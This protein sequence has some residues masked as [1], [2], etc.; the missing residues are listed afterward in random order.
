MS[1]SHPTK[2]VTAYNKSALQKLAWAIEASQGQFSLIF[3]H[4]NYTYI[5]QQMTQRLAEIS[6]VQIREIVLKKSEVRL[7]TKI[8]Y[9]LEDEQPGTVIVFGLESVDDLDKLLAATNQVREE[10][11]KSFHCPVVLWIND[12]V[13]TKLVRVAPDFESWGT[14]KKFQAPPDCLSYE[15]IYTLSQKAK[16]IL[17]YFPNSN[18]QNFLYRLKLGLD[19]LSEFESA[20]QDLQDHDQ[21]I[22][23]ELEAS[24]YFM[25]GRN[26][27][28]TKQYEQSFTYYQQSLI[29]WKKIHRI[30]WQAMVL[31][32]IGLCS[33][34]K[35][36]EYNSFEQCVD[37]LCH[38]LSLDLVNKFITQFCII[39]QRSHRWQDLETIAQKALNLHQKN[40]LS[41]ELAQDYS[42]LAEVALAQ[43]AW[44]KAKQLAEAGLSILTKIPSAQSTVTSSRQELKLDWVQSLHRGWDLLLLAIAENGLGQYQASINYLERAK[45]KTKPH[46]DPELYIRIL[47]NLREVY[48]K[49]GNY[50]AA[51]KV[52]QEKICIEQ[53][54]G[55]RVF[56]GAGK[57]QPKPKRAK[58]LRLTVDQSEMVA[59]EIIASGRQKD[60]NNLLARIGNTKCKL[61]VIHGQSGVGKSS[62][63]DAGLVPILKQQAI[64]QRDVK[65]IVIRVYTDWVRELVRLLFNGQE[66]RE[67]SLSAEPK[68]LVNS[69]QTKLQDNA[70]RNLL[71]ILIFDQFEESFF[72]VKSL[73]EQNILFDFL[74]ICI[75]ELPHTKVILS[76]KEDY[77]HYLLKIERSINLQTTKDILNK[78]V[79]YNL[80]N[81][82]LKDINIDKFI[83]N[84]TNKTRF[85]L[86]PALIDQLV[87][88]LAG[89]CGEIRP[90]E[91]QILGYQLQTEKIT[92]LAAYHKS[93]SHQELLTRFLKGVISDCGPE[94]ES[95][96]QHILFLL[97]DENNTRPFK[98]RT[99]LVSELL[100]SDLRLKTETLN[101][102]LNILVNSGLVLFVPEHPAGRYQ[103]VHDYLVTFIRRQQDVI[104]REQGTKLVAELE[105]EKGER[106]LI[107]VKRNQ[108]KQRSL[109]SLVTVS[110]VTAF[111]SLFTVL[112]SQ[113]AKNSEILA[114]NSE[115][116][117]H[118]ESSEALYNRNRESLDPLVE[119]LKAG[120]QVK[121]AIRV[122]TDNRTQTLAALQQAVYGVREHNRLEEKHS[123][124]H[125]SWVN[126]V[127]FSPDG[128]VIATVSADG[129]VKFWN[130]DGEPLTSF[131][132]HTDTVNSLS[133][134]PDDPI[135]ATGS[136]DG[137]VKLWNLD[138][139]LVDSLQEHTD[140]V[141]SVS[142]SPDGKILATGSADGTVKLWNLEG[143]LLKSLQQDKAGITSLSFSPDSKMI[144]SGSRDGTIRLRDRQGNLIRLFSHENKAGITNLSFS[145]DSKM[146]VSAS[147]EGT[148][149]LWNLQGQE[150]LNLQS[151]VTSINS[152]GFSPDNRTIA[153]GSVDGTVKLWSREGQELQIF[154]G[155]NSE[156][157]S[158]SFS[159][160]GKILATASKDLTVRLWSVEGDNLETQ[161]LFGHEAAVNSVSFSPEGKL[162][163]TASFDGTV[164]LWKEDG[165]LVRTLKGYQGA[166]I[167]L[168]FSSDGKFIASATA[169]GTIKLSRVDGSSIKILKGDG[170]LVNSASFSNDGKFL[171][172]AS[173]DGTV[174]LR[175]EDGTSVDILKGHQGAVISLSFSSDRKFLASVTTD[176]NIKLWRIDGSSIKTLEGDGNLVNS[177]SFSND[178]KFLATASVDGTVKLRNLTSEELRTVLEDKD[179]VYIVKFSPDGKIIATASQDGTLELWNLDG[180]LINTLQG[181]NAAV[182]SISFSLDGKT[183]A[184][185]SLDGTIKLWNLRGQELATLQEDTIQ[186]HSSAVNSVS[187]SPD[188]TRLASG[189][190]DGTVKV[191]STDGT[192]LQTLQKS[193]TA[194]N[195]VSFSPDGKTLAT[196]S[197]DKTV[198]LWNINYALN[199][200]DKL[201]QRG[202]EWA[203]N[204]LKHNPN[205]SESDRTLCDSIN[206]KNKKSG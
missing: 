164:K 197:E 154:R 166:F 65:P 143:K 189:S 10:F 16:E 94:N 53:Q 17:V 56:I 71:T 92:T 160:D 45:A 163:A 171:A 167:S 203:G 87:N 5:Q 83:L 31:F 54:F 105:K 101:L 139:E 108:L 97:T 168:G 131:Q 141:D 120:K 41:I 73:A 125:T 42:F 1:I 178:G 193:G 175:K 115:I 159:P 80:G 190:S 199:D 198:I 29:I 67:I 78:D 192:L 15:L 205:V 21:E 196:A 61:T 57:L 110:L 173:V 35:S 122:E 119:A 127:N 151:S 40:P 180:E 107:E 102:I 174:K 188:G 43:L 179:D 161:T 75:D 169:D 52:K 14:T 162:I 98:T 59:D 155:N 11:R 69:L 46:Y 191:W 181:H 90:I 27:Y 63:I 138:G 3:A 22:E 135:F 74:K 30:D 106:Q 187:F 133:F 96:A 182:N 165:T 50:L 7:Y 150:L 18:P 121:S 140:T 147:L 70:N 200:L 55:L 109:Y 118:N 185:A 129:K 112:S 49:E 24:F 146:I 81:L 202:C 95:V 136:A 2:E 66:P 33:D 91:L 195:S 51:F 100:A 156:I 194:I 68:Q 85:Y 38:G 13:Q 130:I 28:A 37:I 44:I 77:L 206:E 47:A 145:P 58:F 124:N 36:Q 114:K 72:S 20:W 134:S 184:T 142:F 9:E 4:C 157:T 34:S 12:E 8:R 93:G 60:I 201:L 103:L 23:P 117:V 89:E 48:F 172:S 79:R 25:L 84:R 19:N 177:A 153:T 111:L 76:L 113:N 152:V 39:L 86:E 82:S 88:D 132:E 149:T 137:T 158:I 128:K 204:Y 64:G 186:E 123:E 32:H 62:L 148:V 170:D 183:L 104:R 26:Y 144:V 6:S 176:G 126:S 116:K 99:E